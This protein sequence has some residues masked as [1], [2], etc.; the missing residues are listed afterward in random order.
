MKEYQILEEV[1][2]SSP[3]KFIPQKFIN[4]DWYDLH[5]GYSTLK[6]ATEWLDNYLAEQ[7]PKNI[8]HEYKNN[9]PQQL[10]G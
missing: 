5:T 2:L 3:S 9:K 6:L 1:S 4:G 8:I 7:S 10:L